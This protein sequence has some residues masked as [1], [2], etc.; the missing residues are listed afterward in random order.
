MPAT[1]LIA[2]HNVAARAA[3]RASLAVHGFRV[4]AEA[5]NGLDAVRLAQHHDPDI[6]IIELEMPWVDGFDTVRELAA[7][8]PHVRLVVYTAPGPPEDERDAIDC[9][10]NAFHRKDRVSPRQLADALVALLQGS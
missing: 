7:A 5:S 3:L 1:V 6:A 4:V 9:G 10:A 2:D 8:N